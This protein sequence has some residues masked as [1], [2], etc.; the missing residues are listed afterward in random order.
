MTEVQKVGI[1]GKR[2]SNFSDF[3]EAA[4]KCRTGGGSDT[5]L[6]FVKRCTKT[7]DGK[8]QYNISLITANNE[9]LV[10][11]HQKPKDGE[12]VPLMKGGAYE[13]TIEFNQDEENM[14]VPVTSTVGPYSHMLAKCF[15]KSADTVVEGCFA[16]ASIVCSLYNGMIYYK[17]NKIFPIDATPNTLHY[18][19][20]F[21]VDKYMG[22]VPTSLNLTTAMFPEGTDIKYM[23]RYFTLPLYTHDSYKCVQIGLDMEKPSD[24]CGVYENGTK[25]VGLSA[26]VED[27][28]INKFMVKYTTLDDLEIYMD[29]TYPIKQDSPSMWEC[30]GI[31]NVDMWAASCPRLIYCA[32]EWFCS[33]YSKLERICGHTEDNGKI[34]TSS[35]IFNMA[36]NLPETIKV[37]GVE[38][39][40][41]Y[42]KDFVASYA[43]E[44]DGDVHPLNK[45]WKSDIQN[46]RPLCIN[47]TEM[48]DYQLTPFMKAIEGK[49]VKFYGIFDIERDDIYERRGEHMEYIKENGFKPVTVFA[50]KN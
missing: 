32:K 28:V 37:A 4:K 13:G 39:S 47:I 17:V 16:N 6:V 34:H 38:L 10:I 1:L 43:Y 46:N 3:K 48:V 35:F 29:V 9:P 14:A 30:F 19:E 5:T 2:F 8:Q 7:K 22:Q 49:G 27:K 11:K 26:Q 15:D 41:D 23:D 42:V 44:S 31:L 12:S 25:T 24:F 18:Y 33:G 36:I 21:C 20:K 40:D 50:L 45:A